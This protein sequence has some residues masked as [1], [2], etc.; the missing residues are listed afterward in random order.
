MST[1]INI[2]ISVII[3]SLI[4]LI[5][6]FILL[7]KKNL[8]KLLSLMIS[9]SAGTLLGAAF[10][11]L[12]PEIIESKI[13]R[14]LPYMILLGI[15]TFFVLEKIIKWHHHHKGSEIHSF[16]YL[17]L[18]GDSLH[19]FIDGAIIATSFIVSTQLGI[20]TSIAIFFHEIPQEIG[21]LSLLLY[22]GFSK[23]KALMFNF[24][25]ALTAIFGAII[26]YLFSS[27]IA[28][29][30]PY[31]TAFA[32]GVFIYIGAADLIPEL[33]KENAVKK[34]ITQFLF[35]IFGIILIAI[36]SSIF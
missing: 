33:H 3:V 13:N 17:N 35:L 21:D 25:T 16:T 9:F 23:T 1:L 31:L 18:I 8:N 7:K 20:V 19:N 4:S 2:L 12:L 11:D 22:G 5:G 28:S 26:A 27:Y 15:L 32:I 34:S 10:L 14:M 36:V 29:F 6:A 30:A 24:L